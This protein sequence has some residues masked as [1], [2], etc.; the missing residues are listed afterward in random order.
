MRSSIL[1]AALPL[2]L[3]TGLTIPEEVEKVQ[4]HILAGQDAAQAAQAV[5]GI[6][7]ASINKTKWDPPAHLT[8]PL[9]NVWASYGFEKKHNNWIFQQIYANQGWSRMSCSDGT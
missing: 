4:R 7:A 1:L 6:T 3:V 9:A 8:E 5:R 2:S